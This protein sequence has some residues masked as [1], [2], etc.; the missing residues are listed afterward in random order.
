MTAIDSPSTATGAKA[1]PP[2]PFY[3]SLRAFREAVWRAVPLDASVLVVTKGDRR[4]LGLYG[5]RA[6]HFPQQPDGGY[7][8]YYPLDGTPV[9]AHLEGL[10]V[11]GAEY[12]IFPTSALW[13]FES[14][15]KFTS[16]L[17]GHYRLALDDAER[18]VIFDLRSRAGGG[19]TAWKAVLPRFVDELAFETGAEPGILDWNTG[20]DVK[21]V[22]PSRAV[23]S[24][25][26]E[27]VPPYLDHSVDIVVL[28]SPDDET[29][30]EARRIAGHA[31]V[32]LEPPAGG[33]GAAAGADG[34]SIAIDR[35][36]ERERTALSTS[37][38]VHARGGEQ[39]APCLRSL[40]ET[41]PSR[42]DGEVIV[43]DDA[44]DDGAGSFLEE[45][46]GSWPRL[47]LRVVRN[48][49]SRGLLESYNCGAAEANGEV[50]VFL[51]EDIVPQF[52]WL[53]ALHAVLRSDPAAGAVTGKLLFPD[54]RL[55][56]AGNIV[57]SNGSTRGIGCGEFET[58]DPLYSFVRAVDGCSPALFATRRK[59]FE[60]VGGFSGPPGYETV[61]YCFTLRARGHKVYYQPESI[62]VQLDTGSEYTERAD[63]PLKYR[64]ASQA[65]F[66]EKWADSLRPQP[67][68]SGLS[69]WEQD[70]RSSAEAAGRALVCA[71]LLPEFDREGG[72]RRIFCLIEFLREAGWDVSFVSENPHGDERYVRVLQQKGVAVYR[73]FTPRIDD[74]IRLGGLDVAFFAFWHMAEDHA[75]K[76]RE[77]SPDTKI[78]ID[79]I[80]LHWVRNARKFFLGL[81]S[82][83]GSR[84]VQESGA[85]STGEPQA[86]FTSQML[87][88]LKSYMSAD[89]V[90][91]PSQK[92]AEKISDMLANYS[93]AYTVR[94]YEESIPSSIPFQDRQGI[95]FVANFNHPP[96]LDAILFFCEEILPQIDPDL[97]S[98]HPLSIVGNRPPREIL[99]Y[100]KAS[101]SV[102]VFGWVPS[103]VPYL[104]KA[105]V[106]V[107]PMRYGAG[108]KRKLLQALMAHTPT[109]TTS[110]GIEG[111]NAEHGRH[112]LLADDA[113]GF[114]EA[115]ERLL[116]DPELWASLRDRGAEH[117]TRLH[118]REAV[119]RQLMEVLEA[120]VARAAP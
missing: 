37:I 6:G 27:G 8:G 53:P 16:H 20:L 12:L 97:L 43:V 40:D 59:V 48:S 83:S 60:Q 54:G 7:P 85:R 108:T 23:F 24:P 62:A 66:L 95:L 14:Y 3:E 34:L 38:V 77:L 26:T 44:S 73:G 96:N 92:E 110:I 67:E 29:K 50:V 115:T 4:L 46:E 31:V 114:A 55:K 49:F 57:H 104:Q 5:P 107:V 28:L 99:R 90:L 68:P 118:S 93:L 1:T 87:R 74:L 30:A 116:T 78:M 42:F 79:A 72:S 106:T 109:V 9:I 32:T 51:G 17:E 56:A 100:A 65:K 36:S 101:P 33:D 52:G 61:D 64:A 91:T 35:V 112:V 21:Q 89:A 94:D 25:P 98:M 45:C 120:K 80:D 75:P 69:G 105:R 102:R 88:E 10:R 13:W 81:A 113:A 47:N 15:P 22:L 82:N 84:F 86:D 39:I 70:H 19:V 2:D 76:L 58:D 117:V 18:C 111:F 11:Q 71:P 119:R 41:L 63:G 103:V